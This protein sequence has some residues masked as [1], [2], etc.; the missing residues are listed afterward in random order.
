MRLV[1]LNIPLPLTRRR[2]T[3]QLGVSSV[4]KL[5]RTER[6]DT[7]LERVIAVPP[8]TARLL[9]ALRK[10]TVQREGLCW[11]AFLSSPAP[12]TRCPRPGTLESVVNH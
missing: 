6:S 1:E 9:L 4:G 3:F 10:L 2:W 11:A 7:P 12:I 8:D 5:H